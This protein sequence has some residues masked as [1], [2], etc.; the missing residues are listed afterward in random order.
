MGGVRNV[1]I[2]PQSISHSPALTMIC[3]YDKIIPS[4]VAKCLSLS[5]TKYVCCVYLITAH[6]GNKENQIII[7]LN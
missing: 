3:K 7:N 6:T 1:I 4:Y 2:F 5:D